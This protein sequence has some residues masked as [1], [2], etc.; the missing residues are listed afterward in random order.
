MLESVIKMKNWE[1]V[2]RLFFLIHFSYFM[3]YT[4]HKC[5]LL[6]IDFHRVNTNLKM[7]VST[8]SQNIENVSIRYKYYNSNS[9]LMH[10][11]YRYLC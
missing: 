8:M 3:S 5:Y 1:L 10:E 4:K 9:I 11:M 2:N 7:V 6:F